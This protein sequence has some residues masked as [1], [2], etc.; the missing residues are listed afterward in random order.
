LIGLIKILKARIVLS[1]PGSELEGLQQP[2]PH[3]KL[4]LGS[5]QA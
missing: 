3:S 2:R 1:Q 5:S 4:D